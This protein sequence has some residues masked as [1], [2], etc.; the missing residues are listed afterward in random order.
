MRHVLDF[1]DSTLAIIMARGIAACLIATA[2]VY[3]PE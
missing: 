3:F 2:V 1:L